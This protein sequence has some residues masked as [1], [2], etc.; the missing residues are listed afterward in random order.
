MI[1]VTL[2]FDSVDATIVALSKLVGVV[3]SKAVNPATI[4]Q[5]AETAPA[6][7]DTPNKRRGRSDKGQPRG[8][9]K[10]GAATTSAAPVANGSAQADASLTAGPK[11]STQDSAPA[12]AE[13]KPAAPVSSPG[14]AHEIPST[15]GVAPAAA[16]PKTADAQAA[17]AKL[18]EAKG[19]AAAMDVLSR[20][21]A[22]AVRELKPEQY[23]PFIADVD[24]VLAG[25]AA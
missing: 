3:P 13:P 6:I 19:L 17:V 2:E 15:T 25:G 22:K 1:K 14:V 20:Y 18:F 10:V 9:Y 21:G 7:Q 5:H 12:V 11:P 24:R 4:K 23:A 8:S 16:A